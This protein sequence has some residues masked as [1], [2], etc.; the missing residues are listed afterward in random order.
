[1]KK[2]ILFFC[3]INCF[4]I[5]YSQ[6]INNCSTCNLKLLNEK[7]LN[8]KSLEELRLLRNEIFARKG[9]KFSST[10]LEDYFFN[11]EWYKP[12]DSN[13]KVIFTEIESKNIDLIKKFEAI[14]F[15]KREMALKNLKEL[16]KAL[17]E[18]NKTVISKYLHKLEKNDYYPSQID[19]IKQ[20]LNYINLDGIHWNK[21]A[22]LYSIKLDDGFALYTFEVRFTNEKV[23][24]INGMNRHSEIFGDFNDGYSDYQSENESQV[25]YVFK[26]TSEGIV[27]E[28]DRVAG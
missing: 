22:G 4:Y 16:K 23:E 11:Q 19:E 3:L 10:V 9:Y 26:L 21:N 12:V 14:E 7:H 13:D 18:N 6:E 25:W 5:S 1:M 27:F 17:N 8:K 24:I 20:T 28:I 2:I 15:Q